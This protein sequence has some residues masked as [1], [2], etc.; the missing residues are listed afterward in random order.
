MIAERR[1]T[2]AITLP[3]PSTL[4]I[5]DDVPDLIR[6]PSS[7]VI[8][9]AGGRDQGPSIRRGPNGGKRQV[10]DNLSSDEVQYEDDKHQHR[11]SRKV[12]VLRDLFNR[13]VIG[14]DLYS[15]GLRF[16]DAFDKSHWGSSGGMRFDNMPASGKVSTEGGRTDTIVS[17]RREVMDAI[18][19]LGGSATIGA[20]AMWQIIGMR[21]SLSEMAAGAGDNRA[22]WKG[23]IL[24][25]LGS[26]GTHYDRLGY[27]RRATTKR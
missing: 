12:D 19:S 26:I 9:S 20:I 3:R 13:N 25:A 14:D 8:V 2:S 23:A 21:K 17:A 5:L 4:D 15:I 7:H 6:D 1:R 16:Q 10:H 22:L 24:A 27:D 11:V 18:E